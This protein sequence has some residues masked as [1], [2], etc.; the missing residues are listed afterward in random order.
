M[1]SYGCALRVGTLISG[2]WVCAA[3][4]PGGYLATD[5]AV[6]PQSLDTLKASGA[7]DLPCAIG[8]VR[9]EDVEHADLT[10]DSSR[11]HAVSGCG[12]RVVY[13]LAPETGRYPGPE[14]VSRSPLTPGADATS[15]PVPSSSGRPPSP[16]PTV[17]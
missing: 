11:V 3:C 4:G 7:H 9:V 15:A 5:G 17:R 6:Y 14:L 16:A 1:R 12:W 8:N 13:H 10:Q 2:A